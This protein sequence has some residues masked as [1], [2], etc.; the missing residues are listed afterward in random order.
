MK[1]SQMKNCEFGAEMTVSES[2]KEHV[3]HWPM[4]QENVQFGSEQFC[5][6][7]LCTEVSRIFLL[8]QKETRG[9]SEKM[10]DV[11]ES[12]CKI[13]AFPFAPIQKM[14]SP[15][16][17]FILTLLMKV[18]HAAPWLYWSVLYV[19]LFTATMVSLEV[20]I[21]KDRKEMLSHIMFYSPFF[22]K[23]SLENFDLVLSKTR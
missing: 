13:L 18:R 8:C 12:F 4:P 17:T 16:L 5:C 23:P 1:W 21:R 9:L 22:N 15:L 2:V 19:H 11:L 3:L 10:E 7:E 14:C 6:I 20:F